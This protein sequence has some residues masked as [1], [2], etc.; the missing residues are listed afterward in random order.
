MSPLSL[1]CQLG[2]MRVAEVKK[3]GRERG[4]ECV[5]HLSVLS[6]TQVLVCVFGADVTIRAT[7]LEQ[8]ALHFAV[9][10]N[11]PDIVR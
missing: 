11:H 7:A 10:H 2:H 3:G 5:I 6:H 4:R 8:T 1:A 9:L